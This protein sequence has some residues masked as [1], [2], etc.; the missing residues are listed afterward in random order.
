MSKVRVVTFPNGA[1]IDIDVTGDV[2]HPEFK[3]V[4]REIENEAV[5]AF[6]CMTAQGAPE[7]VA[8]QVIAQGVMEDLADVFGMGEAAPVG[9]GH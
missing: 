4:M 5:D 6:N 1:T 2:H 7:I 8:M 9:K 3:R